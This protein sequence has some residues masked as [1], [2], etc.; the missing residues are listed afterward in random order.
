MARNRLMSNIIF[1]AAVWAVAVCLA[2]SAVRASDTKTL[3]IRGSSSESGDVIEVPSTAKISVETGASGIVVTLPGLDVRLR[4]LGDA[5]ANGYCYIAAGSGG[6]SASD[7]DGD[8]VPDQFDNCANT[9]SSASLINNQGCPDTDGD[10]I[11]DDTD[12][13]PTNGGN[14]GANG[15]TTSTGTTYT[16]TPSTSGQGS[17]SPSSPQTVSA[18][19]TVTFT[20]S[21]AIGYQL[22]GFSGSCGGSRNGDRFTTAAVNANCSVQATFT[23]DNSTD[24]GSGDYCTGTPA[25][26]VGVVSCNTNFNF[27]PWT[28]DNSLGIVTVPSGKILSIPFTTTDSSTAEGH[29]QAYS[30][31]GTHAFEADDPHRWHAWF[32]AVPG[33]ESLGQGCDWYGLEP[34]DRKL[35]WE[36]TN[37]DEYACV[38]GT[39]S[40]V[41]YIN[42][43]ARC[44]PNQA[45]SP[46]SCTSSADRWNG[47]YKFNL[48]KTRYSN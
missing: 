8:N 20:A 9:S 11:F 37:N 45:F 13:C 32:S 43:E 3:T 46:A 48:N 35:Q 29:L 2:S 7:A 17:I 42:F 47:D 38:L 12:Q 1:K 24:V 18:G 31:S 41:R 21:A 39:A 26:L 34:Y 16:V 6:G 23:V 14:V 44:F 28:T 15:C 30:Y 36:K 25:G 27:D 4:C 19:G 5:T 33:G 10:G 22:S 40:Q